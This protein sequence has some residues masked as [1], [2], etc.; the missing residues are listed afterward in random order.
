M[1]S[2]MVDNFQGGRDLGRHLC[3]LGHRRIAYIGP[4]QALAHQRLAGLRA[5]ASEAGATVPDDLVHLSPDAGSEDSVPGLLGRL[6]AGRTGPKRV[7]QAFTALAVYNDYMAVHAI[8][9]LQGQALRVPKHVSVTGFDGALP[10]DTRGLRLTTAHI[11]LAEM[12]RE[13]LNLLSLRL[14]SPSAPPRK[15]VLSAV[16]RDGETTASPGR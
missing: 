11:P 14:Q 8:R 1:D 15:L 12:G 2:V 13:A 5:A 9:C 6:L 7:R 10:A 4:D 16:V 3:E